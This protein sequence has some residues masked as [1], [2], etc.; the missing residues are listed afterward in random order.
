MA[1]RKVKQIT[2]NAYK[3]FLNQNEGVLQPWQGKS[4]PEERVD[5][6]GGT[7]VFSKQFSD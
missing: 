5:L 6:K 4:L 7:G 2:E 3:L 1:F